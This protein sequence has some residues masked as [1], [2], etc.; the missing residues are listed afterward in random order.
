MSD[1]AEQSTLASD[2]DGRREAIA[3]TSRT[4]RGVVVATIL[5]CLLPAIQLGLT[6]WIS[7]QGLAFVLV[8]YAVNKRLSLED[9]AICALIAAAML[10]GLV[11]QPD[12]GRPTWVFMHNAFEALGIFVIISAAKDPRWSMPD[13]L[14]SCRRGAW[15]LHSDIGTVCLLHFPKGAALPSAFVTLRHRSGNEC[16]GQASVESTPRVPS[17]SSNICHLRGAIVPG[18]YIDVLHGARPK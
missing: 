3:V 16:F 14:N 4:R 1:I 9:M 7:I 18:I 17:R 10:T 15:G 13:R 8:L 11:F 6:Y 5:F 12:I 2:S